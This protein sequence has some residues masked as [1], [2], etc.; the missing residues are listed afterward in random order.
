MK[1]NTIWKIVLRLKSHWCFHIF[2]WLK[3]VKLTTAKSNC[4]GYNCKSLAYI[5]IFYCSWQLAF[6]RADMGFIKFIKNDLLRVVMSTQKL[7]LR[8]EAPSLLLTVS[9]YTML[10]GKDYKVG[11]DWPW[12]TELV[13][14][15]RDRCCSEWSKRLLPKSQIFY[16]LIIFYSFKYQIYNLKCVMLNKMVVSVGTDKNSFYYS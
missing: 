2:M 12:S 8:N 7:Q 13:D 3:S 11:A 16:R 14:R 15:L 5:L 1:E 10:S 4:Q 6:H 9:S